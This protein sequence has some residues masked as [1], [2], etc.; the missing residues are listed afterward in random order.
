MSATSDSIAAPYSTPDSARTAPPKAK[1]ALWKKLYIGLTSVVFLGVVADFAWTASGSGEWKLVQDEAGVQA[2]TLKAPGDPLL[3][4][5]TVMEGNWTLSQLVSQHIVDDNL[6]TCKSWIP[7]CAD[8]TRIQE[9]DPVRGYDKD[10]WRLAFPGPF[11][12]RELLITTMVKQ[13]PVTKAVALDV[14]ALPN[15]LPHTAGVVRAERMHNR[16]T[17]TPLAGGRTRVE[18]IQDTDIGGFF[19]YFLMNLVTPGEGHAFFARELQ[20]ALKQPK[21]VNAKFDFI[22]EL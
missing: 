22:Q 14:V 12:D 18:L 8:F 10:M 16:W 6:D 4:V 21:Y 15:E 17:F 7:N 19:P 13:D 3:K 5:K 9:F 1:T 20:E 2:Y 11:S